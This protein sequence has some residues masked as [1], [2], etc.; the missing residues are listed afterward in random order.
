MERAGWK[1]LFSLNAHRLEDAGPS[2]PVYGRWDLRD[3]ARLM[4]Y[5]ERHNFTNNVLWQ[6]GEAAAD[7][8]PGPGPSPYVMACEYEALHDLLAFYPA[9]L[10]GPGVSTVRHPGLRYLERF[11]RGR[12]RFVDVVSFRHV[13][14][15]TENVT[16]EQLL[17]PA[18][19]QR[20]AAE[21]SALI[22][23]L[24]I[25]APRTR[26]VW[27]T[28]LSTASNFNPGVSGSFAAMLPYTDAIGVAAL[29]G[30]TAI[31]KDV[32]LGTTD[33]LIQIDDDVP[34]GDAVPSPDFW[35]TLLLSR[36]VGR[37]VLAVGP[38]KLED[39]FTRLYVHCARN[40]PGGL[41]FYG[42]RLGDRGA[43]LKKMGSRRPFERQ[44]R[45]IFTP[46]SSGDTDGRGL[47]AVTLNGKLVSWDGGAGLPDLEPEELRLTILSFP[48]WSMGIFVFP[49]V[50]ATACLEDLDGKLH[51]IRVRS[52]YRVYGRGVVCVAEATEN[53]GVSMGIAGCEQEADAPRKP[54]NS[55]RTVA[56]LSSFDDPL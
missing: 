53:F 17:D 42:V 43:R 15:E 1:L 21:I 48:P 40:F 55:G 46:A 22:R 14:H 12:G 52:T 3:A 51:L 13:L 16:V 7:S 5:T 11:L 47:P 18:P 56:P 2:S 38:R 45:W 24:G 4:R 26:K 39:P 20:F 8:W 30:I 36:H 33:S 9:K 31:F 25:A 37:R 23:L 19:M 41:A 49:D 34:N 29:S 32:L 54:R 27:L 10:I 50:A 6:L 28:A 44:L 35:V